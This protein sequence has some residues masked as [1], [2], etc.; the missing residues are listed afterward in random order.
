MVQQL[1]YISKAHF[2]IGVISLESVHRYGS[3][4]ELKRILGPLLQIVYI[5][6]DQTLR[7]EREI[8]RVGEEHRAS[9]TVEIARKDELKEKRGAGKVKEIADLVVDNSGEL[10]ESIQV[11]RAHINGTLEAGRVPT[12]Q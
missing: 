3:I 8:A 7:L 9:K 6:V 5:D 2:W 11:F 4:K 12:V 10:H 1:E